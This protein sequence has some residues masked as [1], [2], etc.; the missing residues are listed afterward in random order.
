MII[1]VDRA[2]SS[3]VAVVESETLVLR[4]VQDALDL[5]A[6]VT[7]NHDC[8]KLLLHQENIVEEFFDL[9]TRIAGEILQKYVNYGF[10]LAIVGD[11][12]RYDSKA[13]KD[14]IYECNNGKQIFFL[15]SREEALQA[16]H[17][18]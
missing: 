3:G 6:T 16:L 15:N 12:S 18:V 8:N 10:K 14:F 9:K 11:Y 1:T 13:L 4:D 5:M 7:Y 2:G 17:A